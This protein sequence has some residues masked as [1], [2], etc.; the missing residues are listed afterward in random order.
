MR[1][2]KDIIIQTCLAMVLAVSLPYVTQN[3]EV[4]FGLAL[5]VILIVACRYGFGRSV[6]PA[7]AFG[8]VV[9]MTYSQYYTKD[10]V[11]SIVIYVASALAVSASGLFAK[12]MHRTLN[13]KRFNAYALN[14]VT[15]ILLASLC[16][17]LLSYAT[18]I[19][20][21]YVVFVYAVYAAC[22]LLIYCWKVPVFLLTK[23]SAFLNKKERSKLLNG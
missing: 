1:S 5:P 14:S 19:Y 6:V 15:M 8:V 11:L 2:Q 10:M 12:N 7:A 23:R 4:A 3:K 22:L 21:V 13:N 18:A 16:L 9:G 20:D 17:A